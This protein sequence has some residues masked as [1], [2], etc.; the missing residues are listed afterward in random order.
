MSGGE[1]SPGATFANRRAARVV[2]EIHEHPAVGFGRTRRCARLAAE[3][4]AKLRHADRRAGQSRHRALGRNASRS[5]PAI[6]RQSSSSRR[7]ARSTWS[8]SARKRRWSPA[9]PMRFATPGFAVFGPSAAAAQLEGSKGF[10]KDLCRAN[11][12]PT[13][14]YVRVETADAALAALDASASRS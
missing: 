3:A 6:L 2:G 14:A 1:L 5:I 4:I 13:A 12:I 11:G 10:T 8:S 7:P 9:S